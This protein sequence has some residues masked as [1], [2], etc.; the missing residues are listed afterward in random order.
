MVIV[1]STHFPNFFPGINVQLLQIQSMLL[2]LSTKHHTVDMQITNFIGDHQCG[3]RRNRSDTDQI[4]C[5][6]QILE[7]KWEYNERVHLLFIDF[8]KVYDSVRREVLYNILIEF[9]IP[10]KL[11]RLIKMC[12]NET[13]SIKVNICLIVFLSRMV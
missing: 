6:H 8:K 10:M 1:E 9:G 11:V 4:F 12:L 2:L 3:F 5:N 7:K 13:K